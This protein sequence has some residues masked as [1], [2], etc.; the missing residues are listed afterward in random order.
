MLTCRI[1]IRALTN[2]RNNRRLGGF[3]KSFLH[4]GDA[5]WGVGAM[6]SDLT[7]AVRWA[8][9]VGGRACE[10]KTTWRRVRIER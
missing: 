9:Q 5:E 7:D 8:V 6:Q 10:D 2:D 1:R 3:G 4:K